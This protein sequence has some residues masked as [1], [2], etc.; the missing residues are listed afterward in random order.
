MVNAAWRRGKPLPA[1]KACRRGAKPTDRRRIRFRR[2]QHQ[3]AGASKINTS[4]GKRAMR[5]HGAG[6]AD[7]DHAVAGDGALQI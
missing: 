6:G 4:L 1:L 3:Q 2:C 5:N 7:P